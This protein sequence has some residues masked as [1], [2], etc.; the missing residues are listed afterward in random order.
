MYIFHEPQE[1][2]H[3][4]DPSLMQQDDAIYNRE[5]C[6]TWKVAPSMLLDSNRSL[7]SD[8][9]A[10]SDDMIAMPVYIWILSEPLSNK[11]EG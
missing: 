4:K 8:F 2:S 1:K 3:S 6:I 9:A 10:S 11:I 7:A 5:L